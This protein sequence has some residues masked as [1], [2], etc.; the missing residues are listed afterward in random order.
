[1]EGFEGDVLSPILWLKVCL[2]I[3][4]RRRLF[5]VFW[6][7]ICMVGIYVPT[8]YHD[9]QFNSLSFQAMFGQAF[10]VSENVSTWYMAE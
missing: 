9:M 7:G 5:F 10:D 1:M 8:I 2:G 3:D 6:D 4:N